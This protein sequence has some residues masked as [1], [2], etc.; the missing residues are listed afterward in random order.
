MPN[1]FAQIE[2]LGRELNDDVNNKA[3]TEVTRIVNIL[4]RRL[5]TE[6]ERRKVMGSGNLMQSITFYERGSEFGILMSKY[7]KYI[8][9]GVSGTMRAEPNSPHKY[10][11]KKPP[12]KAF[13][14]WLPFKGERPI[15]GRAF[16]IRENV[17]KYGIRGRHFI[18]AAFDDKFIDEL[19]NK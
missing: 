7:Y 12:V 3:N 6:M 5:R 10:T 11:T 1:D 8:D 16:A 17:F 9:R 4:I 19:L 13:M 14:N 15:L 18:D 2:N